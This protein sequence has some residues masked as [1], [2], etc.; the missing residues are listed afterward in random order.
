M[1]DFLRMKEFSFRLKNAVDTIPCTFMRLKEFMDIN[2]EIL[3][4][5]LYNPFVVT[6]SFLII[7]LVTRRQ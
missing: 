3:A 1:C 6:G 2:M 4:F 7:M 5:F